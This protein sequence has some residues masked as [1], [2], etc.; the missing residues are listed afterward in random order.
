MTSE[1]A[2]GHAF[3]WAWL[4]GAVE[5]VVAGRLDAVGDLLSF[6]YA[7]SYLGRA[8][9]VPLYLPE[10]PLRRGRIDP[11]GNLTAPGV[12]EDAGPDAWGQRVVM[13]HL[14][15]SGSDGA[16][17]AE[18]GRSPTCSSRGRIGSGRSTSNARPTS[19]SPATR[20]ARR[21]RSWPRRPSGSSA[22]CR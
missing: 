9:A 14:M 2:P 11:L 18:V 13:R 10:L 12:I 15:D 20:A 5:P 22:G 16:D 17:P 21:L 7:Q 1:P 3:V 4:P 19:T 6:S 8:D